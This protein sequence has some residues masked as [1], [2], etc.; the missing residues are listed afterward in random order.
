MGF[1]PRNGIQGKDREW[2]ALVGK[3]WLGKWII[4]GV[5]RKTSGCLR[6]NGLVLVSQCSIADAMDQNENDILFC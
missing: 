3:S 6:D 2:I 5:V 4:G 1:E